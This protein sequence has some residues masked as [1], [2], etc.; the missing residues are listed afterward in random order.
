MLKEQKGSSMTEAVTVTVN[1]GES[2]PVAH[3]FVPHHRDPN[4]VTSFYTVAETAIAKES[5][6][7]GNRST[8]T[9]RKTDLR[10]LLPITYDMAEVGDPAQ[11]KLLRAARVSVLFD[12]DD[13][14]AYPSTTQDRVNALA[15]IRN[16]LDNAM[17]SEM[18]VDGTNSL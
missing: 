3:S 15:L 5:F 7:I 12:F 1:D 6:S 18:I 13:S 4:G 2:T 14:T 16:I 17:V 10:L 11:I 9:R 8:P